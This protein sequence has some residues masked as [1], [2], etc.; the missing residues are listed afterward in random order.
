MDQ[1]VANVLDLAVTRNKSVEFKWNKAVN[2]KVWDTPLFVR[3]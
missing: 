2:I 1:T 3:N